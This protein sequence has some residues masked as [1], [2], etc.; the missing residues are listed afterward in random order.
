[1]FVYL[2]VAIAQIN[3]PEEKLVVAAVLL[4]LLVNAVGSIPYLL[5]L[6]RRRPVVEN[7]VA[8]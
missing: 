4:Y 5:W 2:A 8:A 6:K 7:Q 3:F 1:M